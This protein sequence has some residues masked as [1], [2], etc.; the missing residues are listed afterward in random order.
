MKNNAMW[1]IILIV[2]F[3]YVSQSSPSGT[4][5][6]A[7]TD[8][9]NLEDLIDAGVSFT[10]IN[11]YVSGTSLSEERVRIFRS[12]NG[13]IDLGTKSLNSGTLD[14][15]PNTDYKLY[16]FMNATG[17]TVNY[18]VNLQDYT[19]KL[20]D[21]VD[22]VVG[23]GC[24]IDTSP[25]ISVR[26]PTSVGQSSRT[27]AYSMGAAVSADFEVDI[28]ANSNKCYGTPGAPKGNAICF[29]YDATYF[30]N[31][32]PNTKWISVT[33]SVLGLTRNPDQDVLRCYE[34]D[35]L[36]DGSMDTLTVTA[37]SLA[38]AVHNISIYTDDI[39]FDL[40]AE[41]LAE[42]WDYTDESG[43]QLAHIIDSTPDGYI[44][45]S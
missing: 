11:K 40:N 30:T 41:T 28:R 29:G 23:Q 18:Y 33:R 22:N 38:D 2:M 6:I 42:I 32:K 14:V 3:F 17:P 45:V 24:Q 9:S 34:F 35:L 36:E 1:A 15:K 39:A 5:I 16:F 4:I 27:N 31:V 25:V 20:Q 8:T 21:S 7:D 13:R 37:T 26:N 44:Y 43:N 12:T 19:G 10:G